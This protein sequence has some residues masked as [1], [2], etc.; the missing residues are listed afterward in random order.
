MCITSY[1]IILHAAPPFWGLCRQSEYTPLVQ[2][3]HIIKLVRHLCA[4]QV[5]HVFL[6]YF[7][8][9]KDLNNVRL[10]TIF[11]VGRK[12]SCSLRRV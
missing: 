12:V 5:L 6:R 4:I 10:Q 2:R 3:F 1:C 7:N 8:I 9:G 11:A